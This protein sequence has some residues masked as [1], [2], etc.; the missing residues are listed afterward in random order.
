MEEDIDGGIQVD[1]EDT[2]QLRG[3]ACDEG[4][5]MAPLLLTLISVE[6]YSIVTKIV[7]MYNTNNHKSCKSAQSNHSYISPLI[8]AINKSYWPIQ[9]SLMLFYSYMVQH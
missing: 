4:S 1:G 3:M 7:L 9:Q 2:L 8:C 6:I 5:A